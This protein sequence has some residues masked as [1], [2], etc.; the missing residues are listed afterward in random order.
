MVCVTKEHQYLACHSQSYVSSKRC[1]Q[2]NGPAAAK[3][4]VLGDFWG[5][6][7]FVIPKIRPRRDTCGLAPRI[8]HELFVRSD[9][10]SRV[11]HARLIAVGYR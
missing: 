11:A 4:I 2:S 9:Y 10:A 5:A 3:V 7:A 8:L 1:Y 6:A